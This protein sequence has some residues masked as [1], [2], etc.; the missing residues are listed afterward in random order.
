MCVQIGVEGL[1]GLGHM[2]VKFGKAFGC[3]VTVL[4]RSHKKED[5][6]VRVR[7]WVL[8]L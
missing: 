4:S 8:L 2:A 5:M 7:F 6:A 1:G 3:H